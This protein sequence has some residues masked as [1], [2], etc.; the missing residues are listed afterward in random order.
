VG[1]EHSRKEA[2]EQLGNSYS[3]HLHMSARTV[4]NAR[5]NIL[6]S[7][8]MTVVAFFSLNL[9]LTKWTTTNNFCSNKRYYLLLIN[10][11][12]KENHDEMRVLF[13]KNKVSSCDYLEA[14]LLSPSEII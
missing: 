3:K 5:D 2:F 9:I 1:G 13:Q 6:K 7:I 10:K 14:S 11:R 4:E 8:C 12:K